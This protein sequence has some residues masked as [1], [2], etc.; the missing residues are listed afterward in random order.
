MSVNVPSVWDVGINT[1]FREICEWATFSRQANRL[2]FSARMERGRLLNPS[3]ENVVKSTFA[4]AILAQF[5]AYSW[6]G[7]KLHGHM[8]RIYILE[9]TKET[10]E[11][12]IATQARL[13]GWRHNGSPPLPEDLCI[14][15]KDQT[16][17]ILVSVTHE[18]YAWLISAERPPLPGVKKSKFCV[19]ELYISSGEGFCDVGK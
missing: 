13:F 9:F 4:K 1:P 3:V 16:L 6:P 18:N 12:T 10:M 17:P 14:F 11:A 5:N 7:T 8:G 15:S 19:E 2:L